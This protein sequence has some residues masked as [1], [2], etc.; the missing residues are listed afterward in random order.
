MGALVSMMVEAPLIALTTGRSG[1]IGEH[2]G[3][4]W[5]SPGMENF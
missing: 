2:V 4:P 5:S 3:Q 1:L